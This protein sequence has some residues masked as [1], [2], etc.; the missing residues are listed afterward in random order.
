MGWSRV[1]GPA[2]PLGNLKEAPGAKPIRPEE[3]WMSRPWLTVLILLVLS[4]VVN[5]CFTYL[6]MVYPQLWPALPGS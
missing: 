3:A 2:D 4:F 5:V 1:L 6:T